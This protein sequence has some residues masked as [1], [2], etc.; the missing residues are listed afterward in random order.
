MFFKQTQIL[1]E[2]HPVTNSKTMS[3]KKGIHPYNT[4][5]V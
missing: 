5:L 4:N 3:S 1:A 2:K